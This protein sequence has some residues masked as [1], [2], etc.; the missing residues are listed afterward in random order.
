M[1]STSAVHTTAEQSQAHPKTAYEGHLPRLGAHNPPKQTE[2]Y[3]QPTA[4]AGQHNVGVHEMQHPHPNTPAEDRVSSNGG[5]EEL[6][7]PV[8]SHRDPV[9]SSLQHSAVWA[10]IRSDTSPESLHI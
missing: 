7:I 9:E 10:N 2:P 1:G 5:G 3:I 8:G 4:G 6:R